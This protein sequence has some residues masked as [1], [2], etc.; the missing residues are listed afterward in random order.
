M[1]FN[2][3]VVLPWCTPAL[4]FIELP[5]NKLTSQNFNISHAVKIVKKIVFK[6]FTHPR[7]ARGAHRFNQGRS[8]LCACV[9]FQHSSWHCIGSSFDLHNLV[10][11]KGVP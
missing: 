8:L 1:L 6:I 7:G 10:K 11:M 3:R 4:A 2:H 5:L 9:Q